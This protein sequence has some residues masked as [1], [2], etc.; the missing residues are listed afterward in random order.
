MESTFYKVVKPD[1]LTLLASLTPP[2]LPKVL[3]YMG[4]T[5]ENLS[6]GFANNKGAVCVAEETGL[7]FAL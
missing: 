1:N 2:A 7:S 4:S 5:R 3:S 6:S